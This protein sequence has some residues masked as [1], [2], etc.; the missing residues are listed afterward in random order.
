[1]GRPP[2]GHSNLENGPKKP[3]KRGRKRKK[4]MVLDERGDNNQRGDNNERE[5]NSEEDR[6]SVVSDTQTIASND[7]NDPESRKFKRKYTH[8]I[9]PPS[10]IRTRG[11]KLPKYSFERKTHKKVLMPLSEMAEGSA[12]QAARNHSFLT[13]VSGSLG[14]LCRLQ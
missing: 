1:M 6:E 5:E 10:E 4:L 3:G 14:F 13:H 12:R 9:P 8:H 11:A 2:G 7:S